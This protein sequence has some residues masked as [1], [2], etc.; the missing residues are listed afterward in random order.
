MRLD[1]DGDRNSF[2]CVRS[3]VSRNVNPVSH[4]MRNDRTIEEV[5]NIG[6]LS[7]HKVW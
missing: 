7:V 3:W 2:W 6:L 5:I 4:L 1:V